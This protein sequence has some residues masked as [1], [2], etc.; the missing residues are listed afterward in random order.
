MELLS[1]NINGLKN[2]RSELQILLTKYNPEAILLQETWLKPHDAIKINNYDILRTDRLGRPGGGTALAIR[3]DIEYDELKLNTGRIENTAATLRIKNKNIKIISAYF[4]PNKVNKP[5]IRTLKKIEPSGVLCGDFNAK[6]MNWG[7][8][9]TDR[10]GK[11]LEELCR[12]EELILHV[13]ACPTRQAQRR[14][15]KNAILDYALTTENCENLQIDVLTAEGTTSDHFPLHVK[16]NIGKPHSSRDQI[17]L[18]TN[19]EKVAAEL[20]R[21]WFLTAD[22]NYNANHFTASIQAAILKH[23]SIINLSKPHY[24]LLPPEI[25]SLVQEKKRAQKQYKKEPTKINKQKMYQL[26]RSL[27]TIMKKRDQDRLERDIQKL[28][29]P[30]ARWMILKKGKPTP[31]KI[32][33]LTYEGRISTNIQEK[34]D[35][36]GTALQNKFRENNTPQPE[37]IKKKIEEFNNNLKNLPPGQIPKITLKNLEDALQETKPKSAAGTDGITYELMKKFPPPAKQFLVD[38]YNQ[39]ISLRKWPDPWKKT[40]VTMLHK[41]G[42]PTTCPNSY[43]P[44]SLLSC[45]AKILERIM[46]KFL[47]LEK[48]P[49]HQF[50]FRSKHSTTHQLQRL[51]TAIA[52]TMNSKESGIV[53]SLDVEAAFDKIP[54]K[55][56]LYKLQKTKQP[57]WLI[58]TLKSYYNNRSFHIKIDQTISK[59]FRIQAGTAQGAVLSPLLYNLYV[60]DMPTSVETFQYADDTAFYT[61]SKKKN[62]NLSDMNKQLRKLFKW[63]NKWRIKINATKSASMLIRC[64]KIPGDIIYGTEKIPTSTSIKYLGIIIDRR[65]NFTQHITKLIEK[66]KSKTASLSKYIAQKKLLSS[67]TRRLLYKTLILPSLTYGLPAWDGASKAQWKRLQ[68]PERKWKRIITKMP[69]LTPRHILYDICPENLLKLRNQISTAALRKNIY[70][71]NPLILKMRMEGPEGTKKYPHTRLKQM[72]YNALVN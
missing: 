23:T 61:S 29:D 9:K 34:A 26:R 69:K 39:I 10:T 38:L 12:K 71:P 54:H 63:C 62:E 32:P 58:Q 21:K 27:T 67:E 59:E 41:S 20:N 52:K 65:L 36:L 19:L 28:E 25:R 15:D 11:Y 64:Q 24:R 17:K 13:P 56:L 46:K 3:S 1:W 45:P 8:P 47:N 5:D 6:H 60:S 70:H 43:R 2:K 7:A 35:I 42:K 55:D 53:V 50:G 33:N 44:I 22:I 18:K 14:R 49:N 16:I 40:Q 57:I 31:P 30:K 68:V 37:A 66:T 72:I 4:P 51:T 48:I